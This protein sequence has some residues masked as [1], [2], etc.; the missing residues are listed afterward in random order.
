MVNETQVVFGTIVCCIVLLV[1]IILFALSWSV[2]EPLEIG[3][4]RNDFSKTIDDSQTYP[5][6]RYFLGLGHSFVKYPRKLI[7]I[8]FSSD[9]DE[10]GPALQSSTADG[11]AVSLEVS[12]HYNLN[13]T[14]L[15]LLYKQFGEDYVTKMTNI[16]QSS[17][18]NTAVK[19]PTEAYFSLRHDIAEMMKNDL[20]KH[21]RDAHATVQ[22]LQLRDIG[23]PGRFEQRLVENVVAQQEQTKALFDKEVAIVKAQ[24]QVIEARAQGEI[25][26]ILGLAKADSLLIRENGLAQ[27]TRLLVDVESTAYEALRKELDLS[28]EQLY[29]YLFYTRKVLNA[30]PSDSLLVGFGEDTRLNIGSK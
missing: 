12:F 24:T 22:F 20:I 26:E 7:I 27:G 23:L 13:V 17:L 8:D 14:A 19:F 6:G 28:T 3:L 1:A 9:A 25:T 15:P 2:L 16:A 4:N 10:G 29:Q 21:F 18:K 30:K 5:G 11:Q